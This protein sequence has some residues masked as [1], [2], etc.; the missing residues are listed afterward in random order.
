MINGTP[1]KMCFSIDLHED[2]IEVP[3][4]AGV[5]WRWVVSFLTDFTSKHGAKPVPP[6]A[7]CFVAD[8]DAAFVEQCLTSAPLGHIEV[9]S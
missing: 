8:I 5:I 4:P 3:S 1:Q 6:I 7:N 9:F 2:F